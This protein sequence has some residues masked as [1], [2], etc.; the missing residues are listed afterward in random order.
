MKPEDYLRIN[1]ISLKNC[2]YVYSTFSG[3][4]QECPTYSL[5]IIHGC[6]FIKIYIDG[7]N[8]IVLPI[9]HSFSGSLQECQTYLLSDQIWQKLFID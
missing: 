8:E 2:L 9:L 6:Y 1:R 3:S 7:Q 4:L 5:A